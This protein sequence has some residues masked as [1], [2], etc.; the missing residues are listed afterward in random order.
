MDIDEVLIAGGSGFVPK[1]ASTIAAIFDESTPVIAP[2]LD[3]KALNPDEL[4]VRGAAL[5]ASLISMYEQKEINESL[6]SVVTV[7]PHTVKP[8]GVLVSGL[9]TKDGKKE[10]TT[11]VPLVE[12][13]TPL[14]FRT[15]H[16]FKAGSESALI[17][18]YEGEASIKTVVLEKAP[19][20][21]KKE[22]D[23]E[24]SWDEDSDDEPEEVRFKVHKPTTKL[25]EAGLTGLTQGN[26]VE[27]TI[28]ITRDLKVQVSAREV[29]QGGAA[30]RGELPAA[31]LA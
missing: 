11:F 30:V 16:V 12:I 9:E 13:N 3:S 26:S 19:K 1:V 7:A 14:P 17:S 27:V 2:S 22:E 25:A 31:T 28:N 5:Q 21:E 6:H 24:E 4:A 23:E 15:S 10:E 18:V 20:E 8:I 29:K